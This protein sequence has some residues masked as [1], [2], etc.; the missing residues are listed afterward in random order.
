MWLFSIGISVIDI[1]VN[2]AFTNLLPFPGMSFLEL[3]FPRMMVVCAT[4][5]LLV[6]YTTRVK[7]DVLM[8][9]L[10]LPFVVVVVVVVV[11]GYYFRVIIY[12][13]ASLYDGLRVCWV[14][15]GR[16]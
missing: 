15:L 14:G 2:V 13:W 12:N 8:Q 5:L 6:R 10:S 9:V 3:T 1:S 4:V 16:D 11:V 7:P